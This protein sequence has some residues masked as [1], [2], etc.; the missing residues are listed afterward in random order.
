MTGYWAFSFNFVKTF[1]VLS[2]G[3]EIETEMS[4]TAAVNHMHV[5]N[6]LITYRDRPEG[7][8]LKLNTVSDGMK[9][10]KTIA[11]MFRNYHPQLFYSIVAA[12]FVFI[13]AAFFIP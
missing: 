5:K 4:I 8:D 1:P 13:A 7:S 9:V 6:Y 2:T 12:L 10:L 3:F 11:S